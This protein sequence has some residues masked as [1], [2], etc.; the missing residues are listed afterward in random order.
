METLALA[1][2]QPGE[3]DFGEQGVTEPVRAGALGDLEDVASHALA[4]P[5]LHLVHTDP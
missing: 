2:Q 1:R 5:I 3:H 4:N